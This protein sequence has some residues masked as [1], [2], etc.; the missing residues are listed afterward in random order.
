[1]RKLLTTLALAA[2]VALGGAAPAVASASGP[3]AAYSAADHHPDHGDHSD[4][5]HH[6]HCWRVWHHRHGHWWWTWRCGWDH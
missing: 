6:R 3:V 1:M 5:G 2:G 4:H